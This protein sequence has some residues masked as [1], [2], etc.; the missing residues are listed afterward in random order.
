MSESHFRFAKYQIPC[1]MQIVFIDGQ[2]KSTISKIDIK[3]FDDHNNII[4]HDFL[5]LSKVLCNTPKA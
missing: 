5:M 3:A 2:V 4:T 1:F